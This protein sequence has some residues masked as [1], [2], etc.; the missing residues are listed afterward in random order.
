MAGN[1]N[2]KVIVITG[3]TASGKTGLSIE[4]SKHLDIEIISADSRQLYKY[5][6]IGTAKPSKEELN[7]VTHHFIDL[8]YPDE[9][10]SAGKFGNEARRKVDEILQRNKVPVVVGGSG[11]YIKAMCEGLFEDDADTEKRIIIRDVLYQELEKSGK[12]ALYDK[13]KA[14]DYDA[15]MIYNDKNARRVIRALEHIQ[16]TG[17]KFSDAIKRN[18]LKSLNCI[19]FGINF[20]R[21]DL[22]DRI[23]KRVD[24]MLKD[25]LVEETKKVFE[26][27]YSS[28]L[29]SLNTV[30]YKEITDY[31]YGKMTLDDAAEEIKKNTRRYAKR[32]I[33]WFKRY[34]D[35]IW[36][37]GQNLSTEI[38]MKKYYEN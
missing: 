17:E 24:L 33:T 30:G 27:G 7:S 15:A 12:D 38:I 19:Y 4:L 35:M 34:N 25:G 18:N 13:L 5:L 37:D 1:I 36:L 3:P 8:L 28:E 11:L 21:N 23:N 26:M 20:E 16:L 10:Y 31:L 6:D 29:N 9:Y 32:Q 22:Y 2:N 14:L